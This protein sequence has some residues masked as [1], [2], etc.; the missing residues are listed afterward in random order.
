MARDASVTLHMSEG[1]RDDLERLM[2]L[3]NRSSMNDLCVSILIS[4]VYGQS[5]KLN[6]VRQGGND[7]Q[8][9]EAE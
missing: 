4:H 7:T 9:N 1:L 5:R 2:A 6:L 8:Q 3:E